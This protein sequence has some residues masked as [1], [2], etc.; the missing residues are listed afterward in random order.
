MKADYHF[1]P[2]L[3]AKQ[4]EKRLRELWDAISAN[5]LG[6]IICT[7]HAYK[8][9][10]TAYRQ[11]VHA[12]PSNATTH[13]FP[14]AELIT[15]DG[16]GIEIIAFAEDDWYDEH[17]LI[18][19]PL[20]MSLAEMIAYLE[21]SNLHWFIPHPFLRGNPLRRLF[22]DEDQMS[23]FLK[24]VPAIEIRNGCYLLLEKFFCSI[25]WSLLKNCESGKLCES[26]Q[27]TSSMIPCGKYDFL[28]VGS[29][30]HHPRDIGF[31]VDIPTHGNRP[32]REEAFRALV[33]NKTIDVVHIPPQCFSLRHLIYT[34]WTA[35][36]E[37]C[38]KREWKR[39]EYQHAA[40]SQT[41][42]SCVRKADIL[43]AL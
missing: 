10:P 43:A 7:E 26:V 9:A 3:H 2:N 18:L 17:P 8:N 35:F 39:Y 41:I 15:K 31:S 30:A 36:S 32:T 25:P 22:P 37:A 16:K 23:D 27:L 42:P 13:V 11:L 40:F 21:A 29:D 34:G 6:A 20:T 19:E 5:D 24:R 1:H 33:T 4:P 38:M 12:Q 14:G 28:A